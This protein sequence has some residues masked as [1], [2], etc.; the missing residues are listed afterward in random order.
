VPVSE[1]VLRLRDLRKQFVG[2][3]VLRGV[4]LDVAPGEVHAL[5]GQNGSGKSTLI[6]ILAGFHLADP[7]SEAWIDGE[8]VDLSRPARDTSRMRFVH[9]DLGQ[10]L[11]LDAVDN[12]GLSQGFARKANGRID[13]RGQTR[14]TKD[15]LAP[16]GVE[17]DVTLP[18]G[19]AT[20]LQRSVMAIATA[21][22]DW[23]GGNG[24]LVLDE[25]TAALPPHE[26]ATLF[27]IVRAVRG[28]GG[29]V[30]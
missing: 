3:P 9:Q 1:P 20:P 13:W 28:R 7:G 18:L 8:S 10:I 2:T 29:S 24:V 14:R 15:A 17:I 4:S 25:P 27:D 5:I 23:P 11:E 21:L 26:V 22:E 12:M 30:I 19:Q 6:K 16:F